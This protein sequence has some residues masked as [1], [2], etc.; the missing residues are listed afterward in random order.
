MIPHPHLD[1]LKRYFE[2]LRPE[3]VAHMGRHYGEHAYFRDPFNEV[4]GLPDAWHERW[5]ERALHIPILGPIRA[6][7]LANAAAM[8]LSQAKLRI[9]AF[10]G[11]QPPARSGANS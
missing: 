11:F 5:S 4:R 2:Q 9:G 3:D 1:S 7:N 6:Y 8:V 10:E